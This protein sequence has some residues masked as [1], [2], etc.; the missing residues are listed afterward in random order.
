MYAELLDIAWDEGGIRTEW[1]ESG[2]Y[3]AQQL[4]ITRRKFVSIWP[5]VR[6]KFVEF[7][8]GILSNLR[9]EQTRAEED[10]FSE[11]QANIANKRW[12]GDAR[13]LPG[14]TA[15]EMPSES[16]SE[17]ESDLITLSRDPSAPDTRALVRAWEK[18]D[19]PP[20]PDAQEMQVL[21]KALADRSIG[22]EAACQAFKAHVKK[23]AA[24]GFD[25]EQSPRRMRDKLGVVW[26]I[27]RGEVDPTKRPTKAA[28]EPEY[29]LPQ[30][31]PAELRSKALDEKFE[32]EMAEKRAANGGAK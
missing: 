4:G 31:T 20:L 5:S 19:L 24:D 9:L 12:S 29:K 27:V 25:L 3:L 10:K 16:E 30:Y 17:S 32:R 1:I 8:P 7:S 22:F 13:A 15:T 21:A 18:A 28:P 11:K 23:L 6:E 2:S 26:A 14:G